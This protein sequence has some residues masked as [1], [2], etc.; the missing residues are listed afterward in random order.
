MNFEELKFAL[1][2]QGDDRRADEPDIEEVRQNVMKSRRRLNVRDLR[3]FGACAFVFVMFLPI[4]FTNMPWMTRMGALVSSVAVVYIGLSLHWGRCRHQSWMEFSV[5][6]FLEA[7][8]AHLDYQIR[9]LRNVSWWYLAP[10][11]VGYLMFVWGLL[12]TPVALLA[13]AGYFL[14]D[15]VI[16]F[17]NHRA[18]LEDLLPQKNELMRVYQ[19]LNDNV[20]ANPFPEFS[21]D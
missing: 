4:V 7:E 13:S 19:S 9:L 8:I 3:E 2:E 15:R 18:I 21:E 1:D 16:C 11:A 14:L 5:R 12:P 6:E 10:V 17:M 20:E